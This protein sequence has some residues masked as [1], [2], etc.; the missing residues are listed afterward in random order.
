MATTTA[1]IPGL[2]R[3]LRTAREAGCPAAQARNFLRAGVVLQARQLAA[4]A[5]AR[6]CDHP[7]GPTEVGYGGARGGGKSHWLLA[8]MAADDAQRC[9]GYKGLILRKVG[10]AARESFEDLRP[11]VLGHL[12]HEY[13]RD[14]TLSFPNGSRIVIGHF[15]R[16]GD[17]DAYLGLEYDGIGLEESTTLSTAKD[18]AIAGCLRS[19]KPH[20]RPRRYHT[21]NPGGVGHQRFKLAFVVPFRDGRETSTRF[22]PATSRDNAFLNREYH[23]WLDTLTGWLRKAWRDGDW[24]VLAGQYFTTWDRSVH[25]VPPVAVPAGWQAWLG[26]DYGFTHYTYAC[27]IVETNDRDL[28]VAAEHAERGWLVPRH[29]AAIHAMLARHGVAPGRLLGV[30]AGADVFSKRHQGGTIAEDY[31]AAKLPDGRTPNPHR[32]FLRPANDARIGG[33]AEVLARLGDVRADPPIRPTLYIS[34]ACPRLI[35]CLPALE[36]DPHR[37]ED[38]L[39]SDTDADGVGGDDPYDGCRYGVMAA[40]GRKVLRFM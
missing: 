5:A 3:Y 34:E 31:A 16:E 19:S 18:R 15:Q 12:P 21:T 36:H 8:Q 33:A 24:D 13:R 7:D 14:G 10:K 17:V 28:I 29:A 27:L 30:Y 39:K 25:V 26:F 4:S 6:A 40:A 9:P 23:A 20:W 32:L 2:D 22:I 38:V 37:P 1:T 35:E 11:K